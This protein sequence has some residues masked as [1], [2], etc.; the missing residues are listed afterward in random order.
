MN[1]VCVSMIVKNEAPLIANALRSVKPYISAW[2]IV[3]TGS[4]DGTQDIIR[5]EMESIPGTLEEKP[6]IN[7]SENRN[8]ALD[9]AIQQL[10]K[11]FTIHTSGVNRPGYILV[12]DADD[13]MEFPDNFKWPALTHDGYLIEH[14][15]GSTHYQRVQLVSASKKWRYMG[16]THEVL[17][18]QEPNE[19][20]GLIDQVKTRCNVGD[21][22]YKPDRFKRDI[23]ELEK[24]L[25]KEPNH[26]RYLFYLAQSYR[27][28]GNVD[29]ALKYYR[30]RAE[31]G[32]W[33]QE[34]YCARVETAKLLDY[35]GNKTGAL[36]EYLFAH[37]LCPTRAE[38]L[39]NAATV[40]R[41]MS[42]YQLAYLLASQAVKIMRPKDALFTDEDVY[43]WRAMDELSLAAFYTGRRQE[44]LMLM[45]KLV[46][47]APEAQQPR[48][49]DNL[50]F[51]TA[52]ELGAA[53]S[54]AETEQ[55]LA[56]QAERPVPPEAR[57][58]P[59]NAG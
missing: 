46:N 19:T 47:A 48:M 25:K 53:A 17:V 55:P 51:F 23:E 42:R 33:A 16:P 37:D 58:V 56:P 40:A 43:T 28:S 22:S 38:A 45:R 6:W 44:A 57:L 32:G 35:K 54:E 15:L 41:L 30:K 24:A 2:A 10:E 49:K 20:H 1:N 11:S 36:A 12:L 21:R 29:K 52:E 5:K 31:L 59:R 39:C 26:T 8:Q 9:L 13:V 14:I 4:T 34:A 27:D 7:F 18:M 3:D 50:S